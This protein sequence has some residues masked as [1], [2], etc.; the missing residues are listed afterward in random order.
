MFAVSCANHFSMRPSRIDVLLSLIS[1]TIVG[2]HAHRLLALAAYVQHL[3]PALARELVLL[4]TI[5]AGTTVCFR[6]VATGLRC[7]ERRRV[8]RE[9]RRAMA[10][11]VQSELRPGGTFHQTRVVGT[12]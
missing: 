5:L 12:D 1:F 9:E 3:D 4:A 10:A 2:F 11:R 7:L 8:L 6:L